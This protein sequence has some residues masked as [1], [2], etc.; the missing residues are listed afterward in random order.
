[1]SVAFLI[2]TQKVFEYCGGLRAVG[3]FVNRSAMFV[4][5][6]FKSMFGFSDSGYIVW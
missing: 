3:L 1:M 6:V 5:G 2:V 4:E